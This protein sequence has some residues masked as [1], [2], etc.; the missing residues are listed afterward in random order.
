[1]FWLVVPMALAAPPTL[2][3][4]DLSPG[5]VAHLEIGG[6]SPG[7]TVGVAFGLGE[8]PGPCPGLLAGDCLS[9]TRA[10]LLGTGTST[11]PTVDLPLVVPA[12]VPPGAL[13]LFQPFEAG[14]GVGTVVEATVGP[15]VPAPDPSVGVIGLWTLVAAG[16]P[17]TAVPADTVFYTFYEDGSF[18]LARC[19]AP[20]GSWEVDASG[21]AIRLDLGFPLLWEVIALDGDDLV[22]QEASD[23]F[24]AARR[25]DCG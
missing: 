23:Q 2:T 16:P 20:M 17:V 11:G 1:M 10:R 7:A 6:G 3:V 19:G 15:P 22:F 18:S 8:G 21:E 24:Y 9:L 13:A 4:H 14:L 12:S 5:G 25:P